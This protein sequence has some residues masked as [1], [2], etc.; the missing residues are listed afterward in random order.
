MEKLLGIKDNILNSKKFNILKNYLE[1]FFSSDFYIIA[2]FLIAII[3]WK[4]QLIWLIF[5]ISVLVL[6]I[7]YLLK[8]SKLRLIPLA[9]SIIIS[10]RLDVLTEYFILFIVSGIII[11]LL[12]VF[13]LVRKKIHF[14]NGI[15]IG[16]ILVFFSKI[17]SLINSPVLASSIQGVGMWGFYSILFLYLINE[18]DINK[19]IKYS[20]YYFSKTLVYLSLAVFIEIILYYFENGLGHNIIQFYGRDDI[21]FGWA[22]PSLVA[23][24]YL[25]I[26]PILLYYYSLNQRKYYLLLI[27][28]I[29]LLMLHLMLSRGAYLAMII[30]VLP[31]VLK[32]IHDV[33]HKTDFIKALI[34][35]VIIVLL[36]MILVAIPTGYVKEF[37]DFLSS[38]GPTTQ[39]RQLMSNI[40]LNVFQQ[41]PLFGGGA[42]SSEYYLSIGIDSKYYENVIVQTLANTGVVG[43]ISFVYYI[44]QVFKYSL[45][46]NRFNS[47]ILIIVI[48]LIIEG[49]VE[50]TFYTPLIMVMLAFIFPLLATDVENE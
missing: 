16:M 11:I 50:T 40:G 47:Y 37:F 41:Y 45:I 23:N 31:L 27:I 43:F 32:V 2:I 22:V 7:I 35:S 9:L 5:S 48:A 39:E 12:F 33:K 28:A 4:F 20:R 38:K 49:L 13:N 8:I 10:L 26:L 21:H 24:L 30:L 18:N 19:N 46:K 1:K 44:I 34:Y 15:F 17:F 42:S 3:N 25:I 29:D 14:N 6:F 36:G